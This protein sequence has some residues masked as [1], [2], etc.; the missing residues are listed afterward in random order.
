MVRAQALPVGM[1]GANE[2]VEETLQR[3]PGDG[4]LRGEAKKECGVL[5]AE[6]LAAT[7]LSTGERSYLGAASLR[8]RPRQPL[9][10]EGGG[11]GRGS[12]GEE[13]QEE[14]DE[15]A[16]VETLTS[17]DEGG[18]ARFRRTCHKEPGKEMPGDVGGATSRRRRWRSCC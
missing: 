10:R 13:E 11:T 7:L 3:R 5:D 9:A 6:G 8:G 15:G 1:L 14:E 12:E 18:A 17:R 16:A 4:A 2:L